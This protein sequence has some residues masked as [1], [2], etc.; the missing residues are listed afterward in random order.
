M[1]TMRKPNPNVNLM[2]RCA[3]CFAA[4]LVCARPAGA[5]RVPGRDLLEFPI[6]TVAEAPVLAS[7]ARDG[8]WNPATTVLEPGQ[9]LRLTASALDGPSEQGVSSQL[10]SFAM[11]LGRVFSGGFS[12]LRA[13][14]SDLPRTETD[15]QSVGSDI[16]YGTI[17]ASATVARRIGS[18]S[19]AGLALRYQNG[20]LD[21]IR[22]TAVSIDAGFIIQIPQIRDLR[23]GGSTFLLHSGLGSGNSGDSRL[24]IASDIRAFGATERAQLRVGYSFA[25]ARLL[26]RE[27][28]AFLSARAGALE[29]NAGMLRTTAH[30]STSHRSR[31]GVGLRSATLAVGLS[32]EENASGIAPV[33]HV[34]VT[35]HL[36]R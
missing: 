27:H 1:L 5:Q 8:L 9:R 30:G 26:A 11:P 18:N 21:A 10:V 34:M 35:T 24:S 16:P 22:R 28:F 6:G 4:A 31:F 33:Y 25:H 19:K 13:S 23:V 17:L 32:R 12:L 20:E 3:F 29:L 36:I 14:V 15:P 7:L 2:W